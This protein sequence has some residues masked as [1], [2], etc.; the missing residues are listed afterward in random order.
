MLEEKIS[1][2]C[3]NIYKNVVGIYTTNIYLIPYQKMI[4]IDYSSKK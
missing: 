3:T 1:F 4:I 2:I